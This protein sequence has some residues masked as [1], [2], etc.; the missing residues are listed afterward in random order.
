MDQNGTL[1]A[2]IAYLGMIQG[3]IARMATD[4]QT[5]K[6][7][8][9]TVGA[10][11]VALSPDGGRAVIWLSI[12]GLVAVCLFWWQAAY[13]LH[14]EHAYRRLYDLVRQDKPLP[15]FSMDW[16]TYGGEV[17][18]TFALARRWAVALPFGA[19]FVLLATFAISTA[20][21]PLAPTANHTSVQPTK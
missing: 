9:I 7:L 17:P 2:K 19:T 21:T 13:H 18:S 1:E 5:M 11:V 20:T 10:A 14:V 8:A 15:A 12:A 4:G 6:A 16:R 3:V